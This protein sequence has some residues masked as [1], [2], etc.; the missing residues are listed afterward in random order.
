ML[1]IPRHT[2]STAPAD[3]SALVTGTHVIA[4]AVKHDDGSVTTTVVQI[5]QNG[6]VPP[7]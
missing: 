2:A 4:F 7:M 3:R 6:L 1:R 5:G